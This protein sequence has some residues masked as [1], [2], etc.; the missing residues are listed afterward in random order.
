MMSLL[1]G[2]FAGVGMFLGGIFGMHSSSSM[3]GPTTPSGDDMMHATST[4]NSMHTH[5]MPLLIGTVTKVSGTTLTLSVRGHKG[6]NATSTVSY[7]VDASNARIIKAGTQEHASSTPISFSTISV[8][9]WV[10]ASGTI[11]GTSMVAKVVAD[12]VPPMMPKMPEGNGNQK[13]GSTSTSH[14]GNNAGSGAGG[15]Q[16]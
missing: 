8:G 9:D 10:L 16:H 13:M 5:A 1:A 6:E 4:E 3:M 14:S 12:G 11:T 2:V 7:T 15:S